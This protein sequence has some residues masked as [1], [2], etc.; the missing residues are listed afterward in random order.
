VKTAETVAHGLDRFFTPFNQVNHGMPVIQRHDA[1]MPRVLD[2]DAE[3]NQA[4][5]ASLG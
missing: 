1:M 3:L 5:A 4:I 2:E